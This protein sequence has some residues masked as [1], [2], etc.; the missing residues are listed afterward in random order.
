MIVCAGKIEN[1]NFAVPIGIGMVQSAMNLTQICLEKKPDEIIFIG[2]AGSYG[3]QKIGEIVE[4]EISANIE[5]GYFDE[6]SYTPLKTNIV[7]RETSKGLIVNSSNFITCD[8]KIA[9]RMLNYGYDLENM[10]FFAV[11]SVAN[12]FGIKSR[13]IFCVTNYCNEDA[14]EEFIK[15]HKIAK[16][17]LVQYAK[18]L[19]S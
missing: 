17:K 4:S 2:T 13:G 18:K 1:F 6:L 3:G 7:S 12:N 8:E 19:M 5:I 11:Q 14:H 10:E 9:R 15:N 16:E